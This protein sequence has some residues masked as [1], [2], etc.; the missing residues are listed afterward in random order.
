[1]VLYDICQSNLV[2]QAFLRVCRVLHLTSSRRL[3]VPQLPSAIKAK[4]QPRHLT[5]CTPSGHTQ[6]RSEGS[7]D[8]MALQSRQQAGQQVG[9]GQYTEY[10]RFRRFYCAQG[11]Q[12]RAHWYSVQ[13]RIYLRRPN[14]NRS[15]SHTKNEMN[16]SP[17]L[18]GERVVS[19]E[20]APDHALDGPVLETVST[21]DI[22]MRRTPGN[23]ASKIR[24]IT[25][26][27][28][29][30]RITLATARFSAL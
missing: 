7:S 13:G 1:M 16:R 18:S 8:H 29:N 20:N 17:V 28:S 27:Q 14:C 3:H 5:P 15:A 2:R 10:L 19:A 25:P 11:M 9:G 23:A 24:G 30:V 26:A 22:V 6:A 12:Y 4:R 21:L